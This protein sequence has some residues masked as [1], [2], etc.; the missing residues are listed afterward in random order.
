MLDSKDLVLDTDAQS[1]L[2]L[3]CVRLMDL[4]VSARAGLDRT[5]LLAER[6]KY[7]EVLG[8][9]VPDACRSHTPNLAGPMSTAITTNGATVKPAHWAMILS[10]V[11]MTN[12]WSV[13]KVKVEVRRLVPKDLATI[14]RLPEPDVRM[15]HV[16]DSMLPRKMTFKKV[17]LITL[18]SLAGGL[19]AAPHVGAAIGATMG[20]SGAAATAAGLAALGFGSV[21][22]GGF[23]MAGGTIIL[24]V[25]TGAIGG[26]TSLS[27]AASQV[28]S[29]PEAEALKLRISLYLMLGM[30]GAESVAREMIAQ[31]N[32]RIVVLR[33]RLEEERV[34]LR[35]VES[36]LRSAKGQGSR[37]RA[38]EASMK[39]E[40]RKLKKTTISDI[41]DEI[42]LLRGS[43]PPGG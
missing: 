32:H 37:D 11:A 18:F 25:L 9:V 1:C 21:A 42:E 31:L 8:R 24:G 12:P 26:V 10:E 20:L 15:D 35:K 29:N 6:R 38:R 14:A 27:V 5:R 28:K 7:V 3:A 17:A 36:E 13:D 43:I 34:A 4:D 22:A 23:G 2:A 33:G 19:I 41:E 16:V 40:I 39:E 30:P